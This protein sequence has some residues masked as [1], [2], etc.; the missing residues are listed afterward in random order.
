MTWFSKFYDETGLIEKGGVSLPGRSW[1]GQAPEKEMEKYMESMKQAE[2][3]G[4]LNGL[5]ECEC[6]DPVQHPTKESTLEQIKPGMRLFKSLFVRIYGYELSFPGFAKKALDKLKKSGCSK[7]QEYYN[8]TVKECTKRYEE[9]AK[10]AAEYLRMYK[11]ERK[12]VDKSKWK[13][14]ERQREAEQLKV[15]LRKKSDRELLILLQKLK[16]ENT[17]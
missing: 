12:G 11:N 13:N 2:K 1:F 14:K 16:A 17:L 4:E 5:F 15:D 3:S 7:A 9:T 10:S 8:D 6:R